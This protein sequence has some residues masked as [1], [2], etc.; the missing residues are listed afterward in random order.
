MLIAQG[1]GE[2]GGLASGGSS[3]LRDFLGNLEYTMRDADPS[4]WLAALFGLVVL[5]FVFFRK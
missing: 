1:L 5:W 3:G 2:Y 4:M